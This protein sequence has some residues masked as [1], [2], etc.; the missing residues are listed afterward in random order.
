MSVKIQ[1]VSPLKEHRLIPINS[2]VLP[3]RVSTKNIKGVV[4]FNFYV[5]VILLIF[6]V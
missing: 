5:L 1:M 3:G 2:C 6:R 4:N